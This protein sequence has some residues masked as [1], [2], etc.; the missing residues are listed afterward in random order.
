MILSTAH[1]S[2]PSE[3]AAILGDHTLL[4]A[5]SHT[6]AT[7]RNTKIAATK[8]TPGDRIVISVDAPDI[9]GFHQRSVR[10]SDVATTLVAEPIVFH[11]I[12]PM[13]K[14]TDIPS[15]VDHISPVYSTQASRNPPDGK[16]DDKI[17][18]PGTTA[19][20]AGMTLER[21]VAVRS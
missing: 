5:Y 18:V 11:E 8:R 12:H 13:M 2:F 4:N 15:R 3:N 7:E 6:L 20:N 16:T 17:R 10:P 19:S 21:S 1:P 9:H 14:T